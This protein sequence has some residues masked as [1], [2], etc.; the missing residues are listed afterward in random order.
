MN[1]VYFT[2]SFLFITVI[3]LITTALQ[4]RTGNKNGRKNE[5]GIS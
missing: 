4:E 3:Y 5:K 2:L 1:G